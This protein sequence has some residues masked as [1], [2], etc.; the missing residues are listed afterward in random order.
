MDIKLENIGVIK[1]S[2]IQLDGLTVITGDNSSGK[3]TVG[4]AIY[5][6]ID[7]VSDIGTKVRRDK[8][9]YIWKYLLN[10]RASL[11]LLLAYYNYYYRRNRSSENKEDMFDH[12]NIYLLIK[13]YS[14]IRI[15]S[16]LKQYEQIIDYA[17]ALKKELENFDTVHFITSNPYFEGFKKFYLKRL[18]LDEDNY[19]NAFDNEIQEAITLL[20][21]MFREINSDPGDVD[22]TRSSINETLRV[23]FAEQIQP[24]KYNDVN[25]KI[26]LSDNGNKYFSIKITNNNIEKDDSPFYASG[27]DIKKAYFIDNPFVLDS[28]SYRKNIYYSHDEEDLNS[29]LNAEEILSH[30][31]KLN[32]VLKTR[33][34]SSV[35]EKMITE[36]DNSIIREKINQVM[37][38]SFEF[39][40]EGEFYVKDG[41]QLNIT[42][43]ATGSKLFAIIKLLIDKAEIDDTT[44]LVLDEPESHL[45]PNWQ[46][47]FAEI[48]VLIVKELGTRVLLTS[49]SPN[50]VLAIDAYM[51]KYGIQDKTN[52]YQTNSID[53]YFVE[54]KNV[55][56]DIGLIY[57]D[58]AKDLA[59]MKA[60]RDFYYYKGLGE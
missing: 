44:L 49:H 59:E 28:P 18:Y 17:T 22:Y 25:S 35:Y 56:D 50:F 26:T 16:K 41:K 45:H 51:R 60:L 29:I 8:C 39:S 48:I 15:M 54:Y 55:N 6:L 9:N 36:M 58:F 34:L 7:A 46:N 4:K 32:K 42:N 57:D 27:I 14:Q 33:I 21:K 13:D 47:K 24:V 43:L 31:S 1:N 11:N 3:T 37:S 12:S 23:E 30:E 10:V 2:N 38:G 19:Q 5:S 40:D 20:S 53:G 52:F